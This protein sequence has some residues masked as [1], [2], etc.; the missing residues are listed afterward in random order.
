MILDATM[1]AVLGACAR[2]IVSGEASKLD[3]NLFNSAFNRN[4]GKDEIVAALTADVEDCSDGKKTIRRADSG[5]FRQHASTYLYLVLC[6]RN[7]PE[8]EVTELTDDMVLVGLGPYRNGLDVS[9]E[10]A[11][12]EQLAE[13][14]VR[15]AQRERDRLCR[16]RGKEAV[17]AFS[18]KLTEAIKQCV[19]QHGD[20]ELQVELDRALRLSNTL[21]LEKVAYFA[22]AMGVTIESL[23]TS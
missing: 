5:L 18:A 11:S 15:K 21:T 23:V 19:Q 9:A 6:S 1:N 10:R 4:G 14:R 20:A 22:I 8:G 12:Q 7:T 16:Q 17:E 2:A 3:L 13:R